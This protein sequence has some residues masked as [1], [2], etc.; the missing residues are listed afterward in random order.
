MKSWKMLSCA[1][2]TL[3]YIEDLCL[4]QNKKQ[5]DLEEAILNK[6]EDGIKVRGKMSA[7]GDK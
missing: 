5:T 6:R 7:L 4:S 3:D 2:S 1:K